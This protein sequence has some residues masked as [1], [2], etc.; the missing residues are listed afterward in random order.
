MRISDWSSDGALPISPVSFEAR[1]AAAHGLHRQAEVIGNVTTCHAQHNRAGR[2]TPTFLPLG[3][4]KQE[5]RN[6]LE[7]SLATQQDHPEI[8]RASCRERV[9]QYGEISVV[10]VSLKK[11]HKKIK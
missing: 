10:A 9:C 8:G 7:R 11:K 4:L 3:D 6:L 5:G 2:L 1:E